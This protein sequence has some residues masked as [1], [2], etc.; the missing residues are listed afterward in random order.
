MYMSTIAPLLVYILLLGFPFLFAAWLVHRFKV[1]W[2]LFWIGVLAYA[3]ATILYFT[4]LYGVARW[5]NI[6]QWSYPPTII[7]IIISL[8]IGLLSSLPMESMRWVGFHWAKANSKPYGAS[9]VLAAGSGGTEMIGNVLSSFLVWATLALIACSGISNGRPIHLPIINYNLQVNCTHSAPTASLSIIDSLIGY[10]FLALGFLVP[11]SMHVATS[12]MVW[13]AIQQKKPVWFVISLL[14]H[15]IVVG[16][17]TYITGY[18]FFLPWTT[19]RP[20]LPAN[21]TPVGTILLITLNILF[22]VWSFR[23]AK[24][25]EQANKPSLL[26]EPISPAPGEEISSDS[27]HID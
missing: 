3:I 17:Y 12:V 15:M 7:W 26:V 4:G 21:T 5:I 11:M 18:I 1:G 22:V 14:W 25:I 23:R 16:T 2:R 8:I 24:V 20:S 10:L 9:L 27:E 13:I 19:G 6:N